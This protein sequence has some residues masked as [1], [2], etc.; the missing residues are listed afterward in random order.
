MLNALKIDNI[1]IWKRKC[2]NLRG[3]LGALFFSLGATH[4]VE[5]LCVQQSQ[6]CVICFNITVNYL[7]TKFQLRTLSVFISLK[8]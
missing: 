7:L 6:S 2:I 1:L 8:F 3:S 5:N 4:D